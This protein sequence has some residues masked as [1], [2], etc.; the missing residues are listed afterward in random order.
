MSN[1]GPISQL[2]I[3]I[4]DSLGRDR[5]ADFYVQCFEAEY[6]ALFDSVV[7]ARIM[8]SVRSEQIDQ[9][10]FGA[11]DAK[12]AAAYLDDAIVGTIVYA[13][14]QT[15]VYMWGLYVAP[16]FLRKS[17]G[18]QLMLYACHDVQKDSVLEVQVIQASTKALRFYEKLGFAKYNSSIEEVF[19]DTSLPIDYMNCKVETCLEALNRM[20]D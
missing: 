10:L 19:P 20:G 15:R 3:R 8:A 2:E 12:V 16:Q 14:R 4:P 11:D 13:E 1:I 17:V 9:I 5:F 18:S 7:L 6:R